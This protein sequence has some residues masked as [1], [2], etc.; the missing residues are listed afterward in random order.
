MMNQKMLIWLVAGVQEPSLVNQTNEMQ[1]SLVT[2]L[3][4][5][6]IIG[7]AKINVY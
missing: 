2:H 3:S 4:K 5:Y 1:P 7:G 6:P